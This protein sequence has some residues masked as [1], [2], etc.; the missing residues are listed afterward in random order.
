M[1]RVALPPAVDLLSRYLREQD[2]RL[3]HFHYLTDARFLLGLVKRTGLPAIASAYG[4]DVTL[5]PRKYRGLGLRYLRPVFKA[6]ERVLVMSEDMRDDLVALGFPPPRSRSTITGHP[7]PGSGIR[8]APIRRDGPLT[9][10]FAGRLERYK[11]QQFVLKRSVGSTSGL[12]RTSGWSSSAR[13]AP[14]GSWSERS[15]ACAGPIA[16]PSPAMCLTRARR[17]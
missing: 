5:F 3:L 10:L 8:S 14:V 9:V 15:P 17:S 7:R 12:G 16:L 11:G 4:W 13:G 1:A 2:A 6:L